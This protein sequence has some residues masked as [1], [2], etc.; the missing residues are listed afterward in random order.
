MELKI[1]SILTAARNLGP[2]AWSQWAIHVRGRA[3]ALS[4]PRQIPRGSSPNGW[5]PPLWNWSCLAGR[6]VGL[7]GPP[8]GLH[9]L[10]P[11]KKRTSRPG[12]LCD[13]AA[14]IHSLV[15]GY[16]TMRKAGNPKVIWFGLLPKSD[17]LKLCPVVQHELPER[18][19][20]RGSRG[21]RGVS[22]WRSSC[23]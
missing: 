10:A 3:G 13:S 22:V 15:T 12:W 18:G 9:G 23:L 19:D 16:G 7:P 5:A 2:T 1:R 21:N 20:A 8:R 17:R 14:A 11:V 6:P 4:E